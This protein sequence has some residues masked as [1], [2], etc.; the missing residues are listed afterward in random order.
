MVDPFD[1]VAY[2]SLECERLGAAWIGD[3]VRRGVSRALHDDPGPE[4][5]LFYRCHRAMLRARLAIAHLLEPNPRTPEKWPQRARAYLSIAARDASRSTGFSEDQ[6]VGKRS[7]LVEACDRL[8]KKWRRGKNFEL[9]AGRA[10]REPKR[11]NRIGDY[12]PLERGVGKCGICAIHEETVRRQR[13]DP[14]R[15]GSTSGSG[16][17]HQ[18]AT[19]ADQIIDDERRRIL[20]V[21]HEQVAGDDTGAA[22]LVGEGLPDG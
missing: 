9:I 19:R 14:A 15:P 12:D 10:G 8:G 1:E 20:N 17:P 6:E 7:P 2:L 18:G 5:F 21:P 16:C 4:L 11:G 13:D 3:Y 22:M